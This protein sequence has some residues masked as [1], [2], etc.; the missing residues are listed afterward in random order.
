MENVSL[1]NNESSPLF[2]PGARRLTRNY[3]V[4]SPKYGVLSPHNKRPDPRPNMKTWM[5]QKQLGKKNY[6]KLNL[7]DITPAAPKNAKPAVIGTNFGNVKRGFSVRRA[8]S[9]L[10]RNIAQRIC[11]AGPRRLNGLDF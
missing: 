1:N 9:P 3:G 4:L 5:P 10:S 8:A 2:R 11:M 7:P 6:N